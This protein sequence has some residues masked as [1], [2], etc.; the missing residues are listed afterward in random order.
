[1][2]LAGED[3]AAFLA[4]K[5]KR[6]GTRAPAGAT[7]NN[8]LVLLAAS[9]NTAQFEVFELF[10]SKSINMYKIVLKILMFFTKI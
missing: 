1:M 7:P 4:M 3:K 2:S 6:H 9:I 5:M 8:D 10:M